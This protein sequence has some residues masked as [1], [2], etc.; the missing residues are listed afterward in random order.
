MVRNIV[1][2]DLDSTLCDTRHRHNLIDPNGNT[3]WQAYSM[4]C[5]NDSPIWS[6][7]Y[8]LR[9]LAESH[10]IW[11]ISGRDYAAYDLTLE[12]LTKYAITPAGVILQTKMAAAQHPNHLDYKVAMVDYIEMSTNQR[13]ILHVDDWPPVVKALLDV[14]RDAICVSSPQHLDNFVEHPTVTYV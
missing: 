14:G 6:T 13:V 4:A 8:L 12:W 5:E 7:I 1:T 10:D 9:A 2:F 3:D 11:I